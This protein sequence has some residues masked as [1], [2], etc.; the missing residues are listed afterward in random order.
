MLLG[1]NY[2]QVVSVQLSYSRTAAPVSYKVV[3]T[4]LDGID[5]LLQ[6]KL[7]SQISE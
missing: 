6:A 3:M 5:E 4:V 2:F 1:R 7:R